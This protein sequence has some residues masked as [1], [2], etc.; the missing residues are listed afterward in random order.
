M[1]DAPN[2]SAKRLTIRKY[3]NRRYYDT[4]RSRHVTLEEIYAL[5]RDGHE[6]QVTDSKSGQD[7]TATVLAHIIIELDPLKLGVFPV[8]L[9]HRL[10]RSNERIVNDFVDKYFNQPL[11]VFLDQQRSMEQYF[12]QAMGL[13][14]PAPT[15]AEWTK[16]MLTP[17][18]PSLWSGEHPPAPASNGASPNGGGDDLR[19]VVHDLRQQIAELKGQVNPRGTKKKRKKTPR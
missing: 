18:N 16:M 19:D 1:A 9:L 7:I 11:S 3:P 13:R 6:V 10:L 15:M 8:P 14:T 2:E 5:I 17:L 12:R 4:T